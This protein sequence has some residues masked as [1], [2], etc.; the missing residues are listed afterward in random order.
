MIQRMLTTAI[1]LAVLS[2]LMEGAP[3]V[4]AAPVAPAAKP[5]NLTTS[6]V[7]VVATTNLPPAAAVAA[8]PADATIIEYNNIDLQTVLRTLS[9]KAGVS[10][11][12][13]DN[14]TGSVTVHL[15]D[16]AYT[17]AMKLI[18]ESKG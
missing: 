14:V 6:V 1:L 2:P 4:P 9:S 15:E 18:A 16:I 11:I 13:G 8:D 5:T 7:K 3:T 12:L 10:L 17:N